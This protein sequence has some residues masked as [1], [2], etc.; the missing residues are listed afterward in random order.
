MTAPGGNDAAGIGEVC[1]EG[2]ED[3]IDAGSWPGDF[4]GAGAVG[5]LCKGASW[6]PAWIIAKA[7]WVKLSPVK[8]GITLAS[9]AGG[10]GWAVRMLTRGPCASVAP[11]VGVWAITVCSGAYP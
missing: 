6:N 9:S 1:V 11:A 3:A 2:A 8:S 7:A 5:A 4:T 10:M